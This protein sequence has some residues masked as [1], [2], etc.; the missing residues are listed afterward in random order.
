MLDQF[1]QVAFQ[2]QQNRLRFRIAETAV[3]FEHTGIAR[4]VDHEARVEEPGVAVP[5]LGH[6][7][8][9]RL[10]DFAHHSR[11]QLGSHHR[12]RRVGAHAAGIGPLVAVPETLVIL[13]GRKREHVLA[14]H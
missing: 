7:C 6:S 2:A 8:E 9:H 5:L 11:V 4:A 1:E 10:D 13:A 14:V 12:R 3:E